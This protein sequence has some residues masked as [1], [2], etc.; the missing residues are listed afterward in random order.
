MAEFE[1]I[2]IGGAPFA[3]KTTLARRLAA[4][5]GYGLVAIDDLGPAV[6][7]Y[8]SPQSHPALH[9]M[10]GW[11]YRDY[12]TTHTPATLIQYCIKGHDAL[13]PAI[14]AVIAAH[15]T[16][17]GPVILEGWALD[18]ARVASLAHPQLRM[19]WLLVDEAVLEARLRADTAFAEGCADVERF[20][21]HYHAR[22][23]W[24]NDR[25]RQ[26]AAHE[27]SIIIRV[28]ADDT[29]DGLATRCAQRLWPS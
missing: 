9:H 15:L 25:V 17:A 1:V 5:Q 6:R 26:A 13:W 2:L 29:V 24:A 20:I 18:P 8:T 22:S 11:D 7:A 3:G 27:A 16:W 28:G 10:T 19:C 12:Y 21:R 14:A 4:R 23:C